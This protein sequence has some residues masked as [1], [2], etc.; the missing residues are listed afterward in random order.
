MAL[1]NPTSAHSSEGSLSGSLFEGN[2]N[3]RLLCLSPPK[4]GIYVALRIVRLVF[5]FNRTGCPP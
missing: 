1:S 5:L 2:T 3:Y 4:V